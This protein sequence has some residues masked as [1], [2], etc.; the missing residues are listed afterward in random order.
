MGVTILAIEN[1]TVTQYPFLGPTEENN[2]RVFPDV[3][4]NDPAVFFHG[5][6]EGNLPSILSEGFMF[7]GQLRSVSFS[8]DSA[9][10]LGYACKQRTEVSP[11]GCIIAVRF[12]RLSDWKVR[13]EAFGIHLDSLEKQPIIIGYCIV[14]A[15]YQ[16]V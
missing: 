5:T 7:K 1:E 12:D 4:E 15:E 13:E 14:P 10:P 8:R 2:Y 11:N 16:H 3:L 6:A 9:V